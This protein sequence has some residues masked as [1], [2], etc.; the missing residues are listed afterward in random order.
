MSDRPRNWSESRIIVREIHSA[1]VVGMAFAL[2]GATLDHVATDVR[3]TEEVVSVESAAW[4]GAMRRT[5]RVYS[6]G[7]VFR[8][9]RCEAGSWA[10]VATDD[11]DEEV[12]CQ[13]GWIEQGPNTPDGISNNMTELAAACNALGWM[14]RVTPRWSGILCTDSQITIGR[15]SMGWRLKGIP[16]GWARRMGE[17]LRSLGAVHYVPMKGHPTKADLEA[18]Q[19]TRKEDGKTYAVSKHQVK[20][21]RLC[22]EALKKWSEISGITR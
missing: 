5:R 22:G 14:T 11:Q 10:W 3:L 15:L 2:T 20:C 7:G 16:D 9:R 18:G 1:D 19:G 4:L 8:P 21:D 17:T 6:D 12:A 13:Y